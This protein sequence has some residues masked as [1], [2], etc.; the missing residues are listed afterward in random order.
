MFY[1]GGHHVLAIARE[2]ANYSQ[3]RKIVRFRPAAGEYYFARGRTQKSGYATA[4]LFEML[5]SHLSGPMNTRRISVDFPQSRRHRLGHFG[6]EKGSRIV[7]KIRQR[8]FSRRVSLQ[9]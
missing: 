8:A 3:Y 6:R 4:R 1:G 7:V 5:S 2:T 9:S